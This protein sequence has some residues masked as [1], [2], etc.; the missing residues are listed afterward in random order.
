MLYLVDAYQ[1]PLDRIDFNMADT[2]YYNSKLILYK[3][4]ENSTI[5]ITEGYFDISHYFSAY[6]A[7]DIDYYIKTHDSTHG[8]T[9]FGRITV[10]TPM[11]KQ[12]GQTYYNLNPNAQIIGDHLILNSYVSEDRKTLYV[13]YSDD[14]NETQN[15]TISIYFGNGTLFYN[16]TYF[17][18]SLNLNF[19]TTDYVNES[20]RIVYNINHETFGE[21]NY[22]MSIFAPFGYN[23][24]IS[25]YLYE[26]ISLGII[27]LIGGITTRKSLIIGMVLTMSSVLIFYGIGWLPLSP[28]SIGFIIFLLVLSIISHIKSGGVE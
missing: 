26:L 6:L 24:G 2:D 28:L 3:N 13:K 11:E 8:Y 1:H 27:L 4:I 19:N 14:L 12:L 22:E 23:L 20:W 5:T 17:S 10:V 7:E 16:N 25:S 18:N 15:V 9:E 21:V